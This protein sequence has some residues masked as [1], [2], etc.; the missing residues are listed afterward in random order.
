[1]AVSWTTD[2]GETWSRQ[3]LCSIDSEALTVE[4]DPQ[5]SDIVWVAGGSNTQ[6]LIYNTVDGGNNWQPVETVGLSG[7]VRD[8]QI[9]PDNS[10]DMYAATE[11][12]IYRSLDGGQTWTTS[13]SVPSN[14]L[15]IDPVCPWRLY[16]ATDGAGVWMSSDYGQN[17]E[18][19][20]QELIDPRGTDLAIYP[21]HWLFVATRGSGA[22]RYD[23]SQ[24]GCEES[25]LFPTQPSLF[26]VPNPARGAVVFNL[27]V[28]GGCHA[29]IKVYDASGRLVATPLNGLVSAG[30][31]CIVWAPDE[32]MAS[33][34]YLYR[35]TSDDF[36]SSGKLILVR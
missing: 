10:S 25:E 26:P 1:M 22:F 34:F 8:L 35:L 9:H 29:S 30:N 20:G 12:G 21:D 16:A 32:D 28:P 18:E 11:N 27:D 6:Q 2:G 24:L 13:L 7:K 36:V 14:T 33:G 15:L 3:V 19:L 5:N 31:N 23:I 4:L 17:W